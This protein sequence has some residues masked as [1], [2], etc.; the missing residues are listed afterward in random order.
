MHPLSISVTISN[1]HI[2]FLKHFKVVTSLKS[3]DNFPQRLGPKWRRE[4]L[5]YVTVL[6][7]AAEKS[8]CLKLYLDLCLSLQYYERDFFQKAKRD[9]V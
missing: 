1:V 6:Y 5:P 8:D 7:L 3:G 4:C 9:L 2:L